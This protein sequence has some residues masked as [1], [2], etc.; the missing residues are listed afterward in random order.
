MATFTIEEKKPTICFAT[1]CKNEEHCIR[2]TLES[3]YK[4]I[5]T[6]V[7][8][9]TGSTDKTCEIVTEFFK[10]KGIDGQLYCEEW[11]GFDYNKTKMFEI[12][13]NK[14]DYILH[15]D[16]DDLLIGDFKFD[17][18]APY[19]DTYN[20]TT[21]RFGLDYNC[22]YLWKGS[23]KWKWCGVA[24]TIV[25]CL[26][27]KNGV[28]GQSDELINE[29]IYVISRDTGNRSNDPLK[30]AKDAERLKKQFFQTLYEDPD[31]LNR[32]SCFYTAQS[33]M[34]AKNYVE[35]IK[36]YYLYTQLKN[37]WCEEEYE[38]NV[39]IARC[40][41]TLDHPYEEVKKYID[42]AIAIFD[43]RAEPYYILGKHANGKKRW[44]EAYT[45]L[46]LAL[47]QDYSNARKKYKLFVSRDLYG[48][49]VKDELSVACFW[50]NR[51]KEGMVYLNDILNDEDFAVHKPRLEENVKHFNDRLDLEK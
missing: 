22:T 40:L 2:E 7:V 43:D 15:L 34:D 27:R 30:Y 39:R 44:Q 14:A 12:A 8:H 46:N 41:I 21:R 19:K 37:T 16:A 11:Q 20:M 17:V 26:D 47:E 1:M 35:A 18:E 51:L 45:L 28:Y 42:K 10:E 25:K 36:W 33:Y 48:K 5:D 6:W 50:T 4:Y 29:D 9:D 24:H 23:L 38:S 13:Y 3:V 31:G 49:F 32:R